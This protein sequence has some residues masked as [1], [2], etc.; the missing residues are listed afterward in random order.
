M[1]KS[2]NF[3]HKRMIEGLPVSA[4]SYQK[5]E[6]MGYVQISNMELFH[7]TYPRYFSWTCRGIKRTWT[8]FH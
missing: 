2:M 1:M 3:S 7:L 8:F 5:R 6:V 4:K